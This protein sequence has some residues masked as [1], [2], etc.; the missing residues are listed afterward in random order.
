MTIATSA[1]SI[2]NSDAKE[3]L[4]QLV[5]EAVVNTVDLLVPPLGRTDTG[6]IQLIFSSHR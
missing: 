3:A 4:P 1:L 5:L 2:D 6:R